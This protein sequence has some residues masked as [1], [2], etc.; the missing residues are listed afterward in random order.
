[1]QPPAPGAPRP[2]LA[3]TRQYIKSLSFGSPT[4]ARYQDATMPA[5]EFSS[6][7]LTVSPVAGAAFEVV[8]VVHAAA[9]RNDIVGYSLKLAY[10]GLFEVRN[11]PP[12]HRDATLHI[13]AA[14]L[15]FPFMRKILMNL[16]CLNGF[17]YRPGPTVDFVSLYAKELASRRRIG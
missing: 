10:A 5:R 11:M 9:K 17:P 14:E 13:Q 12:E 3:V 8:L 16:L 4:M 6:L 15:L 1:M 7:D 2:Y